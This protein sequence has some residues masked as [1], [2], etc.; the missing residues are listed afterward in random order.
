MWSVE[1]SVEL[2]QNLEMVRECERDK[3]QVFEIFVGAG[4][5]TS[6]PS[7]PA[8]TCRRGQD[9]QSRQRWGQVTTCFVCELAFK[10]TPILT[11]IYFLYK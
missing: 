11:C 7:L 10:F 2:N 1:I 3:E 6:D 5:D 9:K 4:K 8:G